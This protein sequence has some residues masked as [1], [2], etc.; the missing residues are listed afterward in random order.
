MLKYE[1]IKTF[2]ALDVFDAV[3]KRW[4]LDVEGEFN[5]INCPPQDGAVLFTIPLDAEELNDLNP[6][7]RYVAMTLWEMSDM[8]KGESCYIHFSW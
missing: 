6:A 4:N 8:E 7:E 1:M 5:E 2:D 3:R